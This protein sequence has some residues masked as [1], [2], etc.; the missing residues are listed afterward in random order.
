MKFCFL[1]IESST[2]RVDGNVKLIKSRREEL[3]N[4]VKSEDPTAVKLRDVFAE[5]DN[6]K[7]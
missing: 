7:R 2:D 6:L 4:L 1:S 3:I 5:Y